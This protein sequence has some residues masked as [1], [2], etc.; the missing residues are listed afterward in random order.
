MDQQ[1]WVPVVLLLPLGRA[2]LRSAV[3]R[4]MFSK[5]QLWGL[6]TAAWRIVRLLT[7]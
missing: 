2:D 7:L 4:F 1:Q 3:L 6:A 5:A